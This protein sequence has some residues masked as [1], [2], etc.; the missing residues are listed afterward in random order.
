MKLLR[1]SS[2]PLLLLAIV[3][4]FPSGCQ[5]GDETEAPQKVLREGPPPLDDPTYMSLGT[6]VVN[7]PDGKYYLKTTM[8]LAFTDSGPMEWM[9]ARIPLVKDM[10]IRHLQSISVEQLEDLRYRQILKND[11]MI[12]LNSLF[13]NEPPWDDLD[14]VKRILFTEFYK[15]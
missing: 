11:L 5:S 12:R 7:M 1:L 6:F 15:Q 10:I 9:N 8:S 4:L 14:P 3:A 2:L 13:P